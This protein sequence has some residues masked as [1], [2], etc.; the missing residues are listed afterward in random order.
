L[1]SEDILFF[2]FIIIKHLV[3][4]RIIVFALVVLTAVTAWGQNDKFTNAML[5]VMQ[6][7]GEAQTFEEHQDVANSFARI[8]EAE[9]G[10]W[11]PLYYAALNNIIMSFM[12]IDPEQKEKLIA[13]AE[14]QVDAGLKLKPEESELMVLKILTYY[15]R[16]ALSPMDAMYLIGDANTLTDRAKELAPDNPRIYLEQAEAIFNMPPQFGGGPEAAIPVLEEAMEKFDTFVPDGPLAPNWGRD[17]CEILLR[18]AEE[19]CREENNK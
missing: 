13:L 17:R 10:E 16:M 1:L 12:D 6:K 5:A 2:N 19:A 3:M 18:Q 15:G 4:K 7:S 9:K 8:A 14:S 11:A